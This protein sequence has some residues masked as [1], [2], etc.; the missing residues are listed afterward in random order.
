MTLGLATVGASA[1]EYSDAA[2]VSLTEAVDVM[3]AV[4]VFQGS[5]G[6][7]APKENL[8]REQ[9]AKLIAY[10]DLGESTAEAL[11]ALK[12]FDDVEA[13]RWSAKYIA[14]CKDAGYIAGDGTGKFNPTGDLSGYAFGKMLLCVLGY[15][16]QIEGFTGSNWSLNVATKLGSTDIGTDIDKAG[17]MTLTREEAAQYCLDALQ[18]TMVQ[19]NSKGIEVTNSDGTKI[20]VGADPATAVTLPVG[21]Q[22]VMGTGMP[23]ATAGTVELGEKLYKGDLKIVDEA[24]AFGNPASKWTYK[25]EEVGYYADAAEK[26]FTGKVTFGDLYNVIGKT[27]LN[28]IGKIEVYVDGLCVAQKASGTANWTA[29]ATGSYGGAFDPASISSGSTTAFGYDANGAPTTYTIDV[30]PTGTGVL[31][32][33]FVDY[34]SGTNKYDLTISC[35]NTYVVKAAAKYDATN[36]QLTIAGGGSFSTLPTT[37]GTVLKSDDYDGLENVAKDDVLLVTVACTAPATPTYTVKTITPAEKVTVTPTSYVAGT[38]VTANGTTYKYNVTAAAGVSGSAYTLTTATEYDLYLDSYGNVI[39]NEAT[40]AA[41]QYVFVSA[42]AKNG[43]AVAGYYNTAKAI[44]P[45]ATNKSIKVTHVDGTKI[46]TDTLA[47]TAN[48]WYKYTVNGSDE[49]KLT[50]VTVDTNHAVAADEQNYTNAQTTTVTKSVA[51]IA[52]LNAD[53]TNTTYTANANTKF[54][55]YN[56]NTYTA[57]T[58]VANVPTAST[59]TVYLATGASSTYAAYVYISATAA[60]ITSSETET[61]FYVLG[62][63]AAGITDAD[64]DQAYDSSAKATTYTYKVIKDGAVGTV[65]VEDTAEFP[66]AGYYTYSATQDGYPYGAVQH[67][68]DTAKYFSSGVNNQTIAFEGGT[69]TVTTVN[70]GAAE[71]FVIADDTEIWSISATGSATLTS[72]DAVIADGNFTGNL[73]IVYKSTTDKTATKVFFQK[74][75]AAPAAVTLNSVSAPT[76]TSET[77][78]AGAVVTTLNIAANQLDDSSGND[79]AGTTAHKLTFAFYFNTTNSTTGGTLLSTVTSAAGSAMTDPTTYT[80]T[81]NA[82]INALASAAHVYFYV[83]VTETNT[84]GD[85]NTATSAVYDL[86]IT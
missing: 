72:V 65:T 26:E 30:N 41:D 49:Y 61:G 48:R 55:V 20:N 39:Y 13:T 70:A 33:V 38:S 79:I 28:A 50:L 2:D 10:L 19:Y 18:A 69:M 16:A 35:T 29:T 66:F 67:T 63:T 80:V 51:T 24:D 4:G 54:I 52:N 59:A 5:D 21:L 7:F 58:G 62:H 53:G 60:N 22:N 3:S 75:A 74:M 68:N 23:A 31:T 27:A 9:A 17:S 56:G 77:K 45:D 14:Y 34:N 12:V 6:K 46:T 57:Y 15:D 73:M 8:T 81:G 47:V 42:A 82:T 36:K 32:K 84:S 44:F 40:T 76:G 85:S 78:T 1:A 43:D 11:P 64:Y 83:V 37:T 86:T 71:S 25:T